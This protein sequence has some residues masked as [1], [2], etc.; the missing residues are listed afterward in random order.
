MYI[1]ESA[2]N[3]CGVEELKLP[4][5]LHS[6]FNQAFKHSKVTRVD[7]GNGVSRISNEAFQGCTLLESI[8][9]PDS[10]KSLGGSVFDNCVSLKEIHIGDSLEDFSSLCGFGYGCY[11][12]SQITVSS[13]NARFK[14]I[15]NVLYDCKSNTLVRVPPKSNLSNLDVPIWVNNFSAFAFQ[16]I[17]TLSSITIRNTN[18]YN[19][20]ASCLAD[21]KGLT[22]KC[23]PNS[24]VYKWAE[25][26]NCKVRSIMSK[27]ED[28]FNKE[29]TLPTSFVVQEREIGNNEVIQ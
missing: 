19:I 17:D 16:H 10:L 15:D 25:E 5:S 7:L 3:G 14:D 21:N 24:E 18:I 29:I 12:L 20:E 4:N 26:S 11:N 27:M 28:F 22:I 13:K 1:E 6:I 8:S 23:V 2:F 9:L